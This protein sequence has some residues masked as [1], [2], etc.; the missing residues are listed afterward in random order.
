MDVK[1]VNRKIRLDS[2]HSSIKYQ[3]FNE[4]VFLR[5]MPLT[6][7]DVV[8]LAYLVQMGPIP[9]KEFCHKVVVE[10]FGQKIET[11][12]NQHP[13]RVQ[14]VRNRLGK[15][16]KKGLVTKNGN[17]KKTI[18]AILPCEIVAGGNVL[19]EYNFLYIE[20][21]KDK[22]IVAAVGQAV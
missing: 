18:S 5:K 16:A 9:L 11:D 17:G 14:S 19:L 10:M 13:V 8:Y 2:L 12:V 15:L 6:D 22:G 4:L 7:A 3:I 1:R 21:K 20:T